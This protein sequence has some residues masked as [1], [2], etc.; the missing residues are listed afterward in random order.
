LHLMKTTCQVHV[1]AMHNQAIY[2]R[3]REVVD[4]PLADC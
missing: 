3:Y 1:H 4:T 2:G